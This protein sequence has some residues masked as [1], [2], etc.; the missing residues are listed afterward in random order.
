MIRCMLF[1]DPGGITPVERWEL[2]GRID[3]ENLVET[4]LK[5]RRRADYRAKIYKKLPKRV[6][7]TVVIKDFPRLSYHPWE[8]VRQIL[9]KAA[10]KNGGKI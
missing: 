8:T 4:S 2:L 3:I 5:N 9:N 6:F 7:K 10:D 1:L